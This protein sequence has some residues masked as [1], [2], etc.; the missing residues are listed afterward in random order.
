MF[1]LSDS[2]RCARS[3]PDFETIEPAQHPQMVTKRHPPGA[4]PANN[5]DAGDTRYYSGRAYRLL[6]TQ[7]SKWGNTPS[8]ADVKLERRKPRRAANRHVRMQ[9]LAPERRIHIADAFNQ[10][11]LN[12]CR[13]IQP[14]SVG[15]SRFYMA[16]LPSASASPRRHPDQGSEGTIFRQGHS[17]AHVCILLMLSSTLRGGKPEP[18]VSCQLFRLHIPPMDRIGRADL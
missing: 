7:G 1:Q 13:F 8:G 2:C 10:P 3:P 11:G 14:N 6:P 15:R 17:E 9:T 5:P 18:I 12:D 16:E 4:P